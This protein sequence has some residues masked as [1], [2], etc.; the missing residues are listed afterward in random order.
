[1]DACACSV[2]VGGNRRVP[3]CWVAM[4]A[5]LFVCHL[6]PLFLLCIA[7]AGS[8]AGERGLHA[9]P[10]PAARYSP[11]NAAAPIIV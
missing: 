1:M 9:M 8:R 4:I 3:L 11:S 7:A 10:C 5:P 2:P 6:F